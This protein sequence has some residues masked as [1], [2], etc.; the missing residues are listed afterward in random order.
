MNLKEKAHELIQ[1]YSQLNTTG[2][3]LLFTVQEAKQCAL[4]C[5]DEILTTVFD[6]H[7]FA[8]SDAI[9]RSVTYWNQV[10]EEIEKL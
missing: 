8:D 9:L 5:V 10:K 3:P 7:A 2:K 1:R 4:I 6:I